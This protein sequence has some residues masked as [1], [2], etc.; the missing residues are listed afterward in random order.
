MILILP[1][2]NKLPAEYKR[3]LRS[4]GIKQG[5]SDPALLAAVLAIVKEVTAPASPDTPPPLSQSPSLSQD[6][7]SPTSSSTPLSSARFRSAK[8]L[9]KSEGISKGE[10]RDK[11]ER[12]GDPLALFGLRKGTRGPAGSSVNLA[13]TSSDHISD[14]YDFQHISHVGFGKEGFEV[15]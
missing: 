8:S 10:R 14:P 7:I 12:V 5:E 13:N 15:Y 3:L 11:R 6:R 1:Q 9:N 4:A 2:E